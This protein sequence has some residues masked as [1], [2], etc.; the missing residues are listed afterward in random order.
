[1]RRKSLALLAQAALIGCLVT[2][3]AAAFVPATASAAVRNCG[4]YDGL[5]WTYDQIQGA[6]IF[7]VTARNTGCGTARR[8]SLRS[9]NTYRGGRRWQYGRW[10]CKIV[11]QGYE[12]TKARCARSGGRVVKWETGA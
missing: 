10:T 11:R 9:F 12:Y 7:N 6:G 3:G 4:N 5:E 1:M 2:G 8:I